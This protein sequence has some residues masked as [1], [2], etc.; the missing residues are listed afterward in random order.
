M[1]AQAQLPV[2]VDDAVV[3]LAVR[4]RLANHVHDVNHALDFGAVVHVHGPGFLDVVAGETL[5]AVKALLVAGVD[6]PDRDGHTIPHVSGLFDGG[7]EVELQP[8]SADVPGADEL[9]IRTAVRHLFLNH[10]ASVGDV[11]HCSVSPS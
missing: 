4:R 9:G 3:V 2:G 10:I 6:F 8:G 1:R 11:L 7:V 5:V